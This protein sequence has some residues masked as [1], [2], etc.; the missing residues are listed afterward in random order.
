VQQALKKR[1]TSD[2]S[3]RV[4]EAAVYALGAMQFWEQS[5]ELGLWDLFVGWLRRPAPGVVGRIKRVA[6]LL[7]GAYSVIGALATI[8]SLLQQGW[9]AV[10]SLLAAVWKTTQHILAHDQAILIALLLLAG[11][12]ALLLFREHLRASRL[13]LDG[14]DP[15]DDDES[16][17]DTMPTL[18]IRT[19]R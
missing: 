6:F 7:A 15:E 8:I 2:P 9:R 10:Q 12:V 16:P 19:V 11:V 4:R 18:L 3:A 1:A 5:P 13:Q 14:D 17:D